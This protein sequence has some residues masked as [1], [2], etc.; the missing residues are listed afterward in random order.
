MIILHNKASIATTA[1][2]VIVLVMAFS[3]CRGNGGKS[4]KDD[5]DSATTDMVQ[6]VS[7]VDVS[8]HAGLPQ[9]P[10]KCVL[11]FDAS[12]SMRGYVDATIA[13]D[14]HGVIADIKN[15]A[16]AS[17][18]AY[19]FDD[20]KHPI[21][22][23]TSSLQNR[24][25]KWANE[26]NLFAMIDEIVTNADRDI[27]SNCFALVTDG[28]MSGTNAQIKAQPTYNKVSCEILSGRIDSIL[29]KHRGKDV[30]VLV[31]RYTAPFKGIYYAYDNSHKKL[32]NEKRP[33]FVIIAAKES[34]VNYVV[35]ELTKKG[36]AM[37]WVQYGRT[38]ST[39]LSCSAKLI[40]GEGYKF[41]RKDS[42]L[43]IYLKLDELPPFATTESYLTQNIE[44][45]KTG[46]KN[47][48][49]VL[50]RE[51][52]YTLAIDGT[53]L[54]IRFTQKLIHQL[55]A[56]F[57]IGLTMQQPDWVER[58]TTLDDKD[59]YRENGTFNLSFF[60]KP[61]IRI[62]DI[63]YLNDTTKTRITIIK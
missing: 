34:V 21:A 56:S 45:C 9:Q 53:K 48:K 63:S 17:S 27:D 4:D 62:N 30:S 49:R 18:E 14:F 51:N 20:E 19:L 1:V 36:R 40:P 29:N 61:F 31:V 13:G 32:D 12:S 11:Y 26:S 28:I 54:K 47:T 52:D 41:E 33:F 59:D 24:K 43:Y 22:D 3:A 25:I 38:Y 50:E 15:L 23:I 2:I 44:I 35:D 16:S 55:P 5:I 57:N 46:R 10:Q 6:V 37:D 58:Y 39:Q 42:T 8:S 7:V 60:L